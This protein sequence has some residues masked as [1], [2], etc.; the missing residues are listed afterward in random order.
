MTS[1]TFKATDPLSSPLQRTGS[2]TIVYVINVDWFFVSHFLHLARAAMAE[3]WSVVVATHCGPASNALRVAGIEV[4][5][6][7]TSRTKLTQFEIRPTV[8]ILARTLARYDDP[9]L[10]AFGHFGI[11]MGTLAAR[12]SRV[13][14]RVFTVTGRG[15]SATSNAPHIRALRHGLRAFNRRVADGSNVWWTAE[16]R[17][18]VSAAGLARPRAENRVRITGGAGV[19]TDIFTPSPLPTRPPLKL[20]LVS[21]LVWSK[22]IDIATEA[23]GVARA[24]GHNVELSIA[25][26]LDPGNPRALKQ[27]DMDRLARRDGVTWLGRV[28]DIPAFWR[29]HHV[30]VLPSRGGEGVPRSLIE[31]AACGRPV[32]T[33]NVWGCA[34][35]ATATHG[36]VSQRN[37]AI[38]IADAIVAAMTADDLEAR[39]AAARQAVQET[40]TEYA[41]WTTIRE[42]YLSLPSETAG[43]Q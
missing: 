35:F 15:L 12:R 16:N 39:G 38:G 42:L 30:A 22:G 6:L 9:V 29:D 27:A 24:R 11:V 21:R 10:H 41:V 1:D 18:D 37:D 40:F 32:I 13:C 43:S 4:V 14:H 5:E 20:G 31:A 8:R 26:G 19:D 7:P 28:D 34:E 3:G 33:T 17:K 23:V 36:W 25:G 2:K